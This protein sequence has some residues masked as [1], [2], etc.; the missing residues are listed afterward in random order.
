MFLPRVKLVKLKVFF[1][2]YHDSLYALL[3]SLLL[4]TYLASSTSLLVTAGLQNIQF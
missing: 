1:I 4:H 3:P 2:S